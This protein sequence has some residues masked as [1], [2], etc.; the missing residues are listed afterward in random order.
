M[1]PPRRLKPKHQV[2]LNYAK[3]PIPGLPASSFTTMGGLTFAGTGGQPRTL[4]A[5]DKNNFA[6]EVGLAWQLAPKTV[7]RAGYGFFYDQLGINQNAVTVNQSGFSQTT[8]LVPT[9]NN[10]L[11]FTGTLANPFPNGLLSP[12]GAAGGLRTFLF[13]QA[14]SFFDPEAAESRICS[15]GR[16]RCNASCRREFSW[17][18][19]T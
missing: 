16:F 9:Q 4:W 11:T 19:R 8:T 17:M 3:N 13:G 12:M 2:K 1:P 15:A 10:G 7:V 14:I 6:P 18:F 5:S